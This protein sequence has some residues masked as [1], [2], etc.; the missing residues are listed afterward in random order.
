MNACITPFIEN[1]ILHQ[2]TGYEFI[3]AS[4]LYELDV[5]GF[6]YLIYNGESKVLIV[7]EAKGK[8][9]N[10]GKV[11][12]QTRERIA[13]F[14]AHLPYV[15]EKYLGLPSDADLYI[16]YVIATESSEA[17]ELHTVVINTD[18]NIIVWHTPW[19]QKIGED[20][21]LRIAQP[22]NKLEKKLRR[23]VAHLDAK[24]NRLLRKRAQAGGIVF[25]IFPQMH[26]FL[27]LL[28]VMYVARDSIVERNALIAYLKQNLYYMDI[29]DKRY[30]TSLANKLLDK[31]VKCGI[32]EKKSEDKFI[33]KINGNRKQIQNRMESAWI[34]QQIDYEVEV[35]ITK[36]LTRLQNEYRKRAKQ[37]TLEKWE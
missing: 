24:L 17:Q 8:I 27:R 21:E 15:K 3:R 36:S 12:T 16:E 37:K 18:G 20:I 9:R 25:D 13:E 35:E 29:I 23:S 31:C 10:H 7:G 5:I 22:S 14:Q 2:E 34:K 26:G 30:I 6:D 28:P 33:F 1:G 11:V 19:P 32:L 4:P